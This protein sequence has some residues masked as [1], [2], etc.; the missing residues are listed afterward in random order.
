M[1]R[2][3][4][5]TGSLYLH[6]DPTTSHYLKAVLDSIFGIQNHNNEV[7]WKRISSHSRAKRWG[8]VHD[9]ILYYSASRVKTWNRILQPLNQA[10][11]DSTYRKDD[12]HGSYR[13]DNLTGPGIR[14]GATCMPWRG[15]DPGDAGRH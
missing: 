15:V 2:I 12:E 8:P 1:R 4:K 9:V 5:N 14:T 3:F 6:C 11:L 7:V 10:Y 13:I